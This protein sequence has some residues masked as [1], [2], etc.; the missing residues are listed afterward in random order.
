[1][2]GPLSDIPA[3]LD[4][5]RLTNE[6]A[7]DVLRWKAGPG[8]F[9]RGERRWIARS[10]FKPFSDV[11]DALRVLDALTDDYS[12]TAFPGGGF[13]AAVRIKGIV[14]NARGGAMAKT[15]SVAVARALGITGES[16]R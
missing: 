8:R 10:R 3:G 15:I 11:K 6:F 14:G 1:M 2:S 5:L 13:V 4:E 7:T 16:R 12:V 9:N